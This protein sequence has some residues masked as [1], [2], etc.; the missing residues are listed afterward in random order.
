[1]D[2]G[3]LSS[4]RPAPRSADLPCPGGTATLF[5]VARRV[6]DDGSTHVGE[7]RALRW[8]V[9]R[10]VRPIALVSFIVAFFVASSAQADSC[11]GVR[12]S[13][14]GECT[15]EN[16][17]A[18]CFC[19]PGYAAV[20][21]AC[22]LTASATPAR[23]DPLSIVAIAR[24]EVGRGLHM[25]GREYF[26]YPG[27]LSDHTA[28]EELWCSEFVAWVYRT[29]GVPLAG[30]YDGG[31]LVTNNRAVR[32]FFLQRGLWV[33]RKSEEFSVFEPRP[34][35]FVRIRT[36]TW[37]HS[38]IV[39]HVDGNDLHIIE[40]NA[41]HRVRASVYRDY[42]NHPKIDGFGVVSEPHRRLPWEAAI[43]LWPVLRGT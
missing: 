3:A 11:R 5:R 41:G 10:L 33:D 37:G 20:G 15:A 22:V 28:G 23:V 29:A 43:W 6:S 32:D 1:M 9:R 30:G 14:H 25:V 36:P 18:F 38:A 13:N 26:E 31:W 8:R 21:L 24:E 16:D 34:G 19:D 42:R 17:N 35:D 7:D 12:C 39:D 40:G 4:E 2:S 27:A